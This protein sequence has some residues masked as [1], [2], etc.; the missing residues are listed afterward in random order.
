MRTRASVI[1]VLTVLVI[2]LV[3]CGDSPDAAS[4]ASAPWVMER[5]ASLPPRPV[6]VAAAERTTLVADIAASGMVAAA[7]EVS[8]VSETQGV[9]ETAPFE[10]G[11]AVSAGQVLV[12]LDTTIQELN[13]AE[14]RQAADAAELN[15]TTTERLAASG[16]ASQAQLTQA[17]GTLAGARARLAQAEKALAD[18]TIVAPFDGLVASRSATVEPGNF[19]NAG[20]TVARIIDPSRMEVRLSVGEREIRYL[21]P[22]GEAF[23]SVPAAGSVEMRGEIAAIAAGSDSQ[24][25]SFPVIVRWNQP[26]NTLVRA[27][28]SARVRIPPAGAPAELVVP[29]AAVIT[30]GEERSVFVA[31]QDGLAERRIVTVGDRQGERVAIREGVEPGEMV[32]V[33]GLRSLAEGDRVQPSVRT[34]QEQGAAR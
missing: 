30:R 12:T 3:G 20:I 25:G 5:I 13:V 29:A 10:L 4:E 34:A 33:S 24:T 2:V 11:E 18:R 14:A 32:I 21:R 9:I 17:R 23:V 22:G 26:P 15:V 6:E 16:S 1:A 31:T 19:L 8:L 28:L 7:R 27:G